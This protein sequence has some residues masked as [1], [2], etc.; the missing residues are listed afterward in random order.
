[1]LVYDSKYVLWKNLDL[2]KVYFNF[3]YTLTFPVFSKDH[4]WGY[5]MYDM[6][7]DMRVMVLSSKPVWTRINSVEFFLNGSKGKL[8][9]CSGGITMFS[10][11]RS[12]YSRSVVR[13]N[14]WMWHCT[15]FYNTCT[16][17][18]CPPLLAEVMWKSPADHFYNWMGHSFQRGGC[19]LKTKQKQ[20]SPGLGTCQWHFSCAYQVLGSGLL[21]FC[22]VFCA[23]RPLWRECANYRNVL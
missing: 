1:M 5:M 2:I 3:K 17:V 7:G 12:P 4:S 16:C 19:M 23:V 10:T 6:H 21:W 22:L 13:F 14:T 11:V 18:Y 15:M 9:K 20:T 8:L